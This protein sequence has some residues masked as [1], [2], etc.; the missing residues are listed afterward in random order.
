MLMSILKRKK[1]IA[2]N[3]SSQGI[4]IN[5]HLLSFISRYLKKTNIY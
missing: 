2:K 4:S 3:I 5:F 1:F